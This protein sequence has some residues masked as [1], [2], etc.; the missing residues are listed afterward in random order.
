MII[1]LLICVA[2]IGISDLY[3]FEIVDRCMFNVWFRSASILKRKLLGNSLNV[4]LIGS[5]VSLLPLLHYSTS[6][7][8]NGF[9]TELLYTYHWCRKQIE[10]KRA[11]SLPSFI[12]AKCTIPPPSM[13]LNLDWWLLRMTTYSYYYKWKLLQIIIANDDLTR[14]LHLNLSLLY[15]WGASCSLSTLPLLSSAESI[16]DKSFVSNFLVEVQTDAGQTV[17]L[18]LFIVTISSPIIWNYNNMFCLHQHHSLASSE[19]HETTTGINQAGGV[20]ERSSSGWCP[21]IWPIVPGFD[22]QSDSAPL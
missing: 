21:I 19:R 7:R 8:E 6:Y 17:G 9:S 4:I 15:G 1:L 2:A 11:L 14:A 18:C 13:I 5:V 3:Q 10:N 12:L 22:P 16:F 20:R